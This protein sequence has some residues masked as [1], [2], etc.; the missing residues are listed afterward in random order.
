MARALFVEINQPKAREDFV[1][2]AAWTPAVPGGNG[3]LGAVGC[4]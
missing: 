2:A 1:A 3:K 4:C